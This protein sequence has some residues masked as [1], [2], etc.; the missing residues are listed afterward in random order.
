M[1]KSTIIALTTVFVLTLAG[2][3]FAAGCGQCGTTTGCNE[4]DAVK[5]FQEN[6]QSLRTELK[7][8]E[9]DLSYQYSLEGID[10][11]KIGM[12]EEQIRELRTRLTA[13]AKKAGVLPCCAV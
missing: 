5:K 12:I 4:S 7:A 2:G 13:A 6:T 1:K 11:S 9:V 8:R 10:P 3:A